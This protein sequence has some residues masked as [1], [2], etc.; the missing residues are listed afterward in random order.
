MGEKRKEE[1]IGHGR[2]LNRHAKGLKVLADE[3]TVLKE[4]EGA[5]FGKAQRKKGGR[6]SEGREIAEFKGRLSLNNLTAARQ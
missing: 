4:G 5:R 2:G 6:S 3:A 1:E